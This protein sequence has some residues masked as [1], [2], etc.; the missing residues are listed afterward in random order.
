MRATFRTQRIF[1]SWLTWISALVDDA[2]ERIQAPQL[3]I[4]TRTVEE[5]LA[6][7]RQVIASRRSMSGVDRVIDQCAICPTRAGKYPHEGCGLTLAIEMDDLRTAFHTATDCETAVE[8]LESLLEKDKQ[9]YRMS[10]GVRLG[11]RITE[12]E[13][14]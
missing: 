4:T 5:A 12:G 9:A 7:A 8:V 11:D 1:H 10:V 3:T 14:L 13:A 6:D 2:I